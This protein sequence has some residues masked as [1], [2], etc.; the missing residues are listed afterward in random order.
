M[1]GGGAVMEE[2]EGG[3]FRVRKMKVGNVAGSGMGRV[4]ALIWRRLVPRLH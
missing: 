3:A 4:L 1:A 2:G